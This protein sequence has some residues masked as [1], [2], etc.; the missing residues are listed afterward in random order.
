MSITVKTWKFLVQMVRYGSQVAMIRVSD[1]F[2]RP[3]HL[4]MLKFFLRRASK[5]AASDSKAEPPSA[6]SDGVAKQQAMLQA[7]SFGNDEA[8][9]VAFIADCHFADARLEAAQ[10]VVSKPMLEQV[11]QAMRKIDR[12]VAKLMQSRLDDLRRKEMAEM[13]ARECIGEAQRLLDASPLMANLV[14]ELDK[15]WQLVGALPETMQTSFERLREQLAGRLAAQTALQRAVIGMLERM[16]QLE[17]IP[18]EE[19]LAEL[20]AEMAQH[21]ASPEASALPLHLLTEF[22]AQRMRLHELLL[23]QERHKTIVQARMTALAAWEAA[24]PA[25]LDRQAIKREWQR[26][27]Q[28]E[29]PILAEQLQQR[30]D[31]MLQMLALPNPVSSKPQSEQI[32]L[33][34]DFPQTLAALEQAIAEGLLHVAIEQDAKLRAMDFSVSKPGEAQMTRLTVARAELKRM[35]DWARWGGNVSREELIAAAGELLGQSLPPNELANRISELRQQWKALDVASGAASKALWERF[36]AA[37]NAAYAP[38]AEHVQKRSQE[39]KHNREMAESLLTGLRA[40]VG[41]TDWK[42]LAHDCLIARQSWQQIGPIDRR[43]RKRLEAE[44]TEVLQQL[45]GPL[46]EQRQREIERRESLI[47]EAERIN[48]DVRGATDRVRQLQARWQESARA[49]PLERQDERQLW[50]R[51]CA[52][53]DAVFVRRR[54]LVDAADAEKRRLEQERQERQA[55]RQ[56]QLRVLQEKLGL[57]QAAEAAVVAKRELDAGWSAHWQMLPPLASSWEKRMRARFD[58]AH[59]ALAAGDRAYASRLESAASQLAQELLLLEIAAGIDSPPEL[60]RERLQMQVSAL[61]SAL[62]GQ[63]DEALTMKVKR[64]CGLAAL[65]D[66]IAAERLQRL[67][68]RAWQA[69]D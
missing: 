27:P 42:K 69:D 25:S 40:L 41:S 30:F 5:T 36:D 32:L 60:A 39:R 43:D 24:E 45:L 26:L 31:T 62:S 57:C 35:Q 38:V 34:T 1:N 21:R 37:C 51:F 49:L 14:S 23:A 58:A 44:F 2:F 6:S 28:I 61:Q 22:E 13:H 67:L 63:D 48:P 33:N 66:G 19:I 55:A 65:T 20:D 54:Q 56:A 12:R 11:L 50:Q 29:Q 18:N 46:D 47:D 52:A 10:H 9:A 53:C 16:R 15:R 64:L 17:M 59:A 4:V 68:E 7:C 8:G 3:E